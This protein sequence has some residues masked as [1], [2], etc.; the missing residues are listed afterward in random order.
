MLSTQGAAVLHFTGTAQ[1]GSNK[2]FILKTYE[3]YILYFNWWFRLP[4]KR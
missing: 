4:V 3:M 1:Q 2:Q